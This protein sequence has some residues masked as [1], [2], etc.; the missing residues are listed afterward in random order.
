MRNH[1][2]LHSKVTQCCSVSLRLKLE[3]KEKGEVGGGGGILFCAC[4]VYVP[5][6]FVDSF[7]CCFWPVCGTCECLL[8]LTA[9]E[10]N[11]TSGDTKFM[12]WISTTCNQ[13]RVICNRGKITIIPD[14]LLTLLHYSTVAT[15]PVSFQKILTQDGFVFGFVLFQSHYGL[16]LLFLVSLKQKSGLN[17]R[18]L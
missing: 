8:S 9:A 12:V 11:S 2:A 18:I 17:R 16:V 15:H 5:V 1:D 14:T 7:L 6:L 4:F 10:I 13:N 3:F